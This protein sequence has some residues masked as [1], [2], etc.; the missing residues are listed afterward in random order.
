MSGE[1]QQFEV[2]PLY[3]REHELHGVQALIDP[4]FVPHSDGGSIPQ[5]H[6]LQ[7]GDV[8]EWRKRRGDHSPILKRSEYVGRYPTGEYLVGCAFIDCED[9]SQWLLS[10]KPIGVGGMT[11]V[12]LGIDVRNDR[13]G[14]AR[15]ALESRHNLKLGKER[16]VVAKLSG[17]PEVAQ[18]ITYGFSRDNRRVNVVQ[19]YRYQ[20]FG[21]WM[22]TFQMTKVDTLSPQDMLRL[23]LLQGHA[24][25]KWI[26]RGV[27]YIDWQGDEAC[28]FSQDVGQGYGSLESFQAIDFSAE[29]LSRTDQPEWT[30]RQADA[31][32]A[33][34]ARRVLP[35]VLSALSGKHTMS[36]MFFG[37]RRDRNKVVDIFGSG[38]KD[39]ADTFMQA[40]SGE[41]DLVAA[42]QAVDSLI[43]YSAARLFS[44]GK[45]PVVIETPTRLYIPDPEEVTV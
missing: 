15:W 2:Q 29:E 45:I 1:T 24:H 37:F 10:P 36:D 21:T 16:D 18:A 34:A 27:T 43:S 33:F 32:G 9:G 22:R 17:R 41:K 14:V 31:W 11:D 6:V 28:L 3:E 35:L 23:T 8:Y 5:I 26:E 42:V 20:T 39:I 40:M 13:F 30:I 12:H 4:D 25:K 19:F 38:E 7:N 44:N